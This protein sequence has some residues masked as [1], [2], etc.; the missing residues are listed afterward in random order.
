MFLWNDTWG[1]QRRESSLADLAD[2]CEG[3]G[4]AF[5]DLGSLVR[6]AEGFSGIKA[7]MRAMKRRS[8][9]PNEESRPNGTDPRAVHCD[10]EFARLRA[11]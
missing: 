9:A 4:K 6:L 10:V 3:R 11:I 2:G 5:A 8:F 1:Y 7:C